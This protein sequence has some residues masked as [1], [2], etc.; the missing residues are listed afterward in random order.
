VTV[1]Q[2]RIRELIER[3]GS[4]R[5]AARVLEV[6]WTY[7]YRLSR[8]E[9]DGPGDDL[10]RKLKLRRVVSYERITPKEKT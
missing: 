2:E 8:G 7:L 9:K 5:A 1:L 6:D 10:L 4:I 3:H